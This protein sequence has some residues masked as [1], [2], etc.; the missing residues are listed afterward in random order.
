LKFQK[1]SVNKIPIKI[2]IKEG[3]YEKENSYEEI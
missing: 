2:Y 1:S 3:I